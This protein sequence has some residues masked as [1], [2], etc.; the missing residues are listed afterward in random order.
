MIGQ[1]ESNYTWF[2]QQLDELLSKHRGQHA[3]IHNQEIVGYF[4]NNIDAIKEGLSQYGEENFSVELVDDKIE[5][6]GFYSHVAT[7]LQ[8]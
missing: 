1:L 3:L 7:P 8:A 5:D 6:L 2:K 4:E